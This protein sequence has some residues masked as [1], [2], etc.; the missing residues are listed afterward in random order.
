M[1]ESFEAAVEAG[2]AEIELPNTTPD[3]GLDSDS[4]ASAA[5]TEEIELSFGARKL[6]VPKGAIPEDVLSVLRETADGM[7][8]DYT[9]K[10]QN[11]AEQQREAE[12]TR[13]Q[14]AMLTEMSGEVRK[15]Y[16]AGE[17]KAHR[18]GDL[19]SIDLRALWQSNPDQAR[20][21]SDEISLTEQ[22]FQQ[23]VQAVRHHQS[24]MDIVQQQ[25]TAKLEAAGR[26]EMMR[27]VKGFDAK[28]ESELI[29][30][31]VKDGIREQDARQ[32]HLN[33]K[34]AHFVW[35]AMQ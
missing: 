25:E 32:W 5:E 4:T 16:L 33:P 11:I 7:H 6:S 2:T 14:Y 12:A 10:T 15:A 26:S 13:K 34:T 20:L 29:E 30:Y 9:Q 21:V 31:A 17:A 35:K 18:L 8:T 27:L 3:A 1:S 19:R 24:Q 28:A 22:E 23:Q